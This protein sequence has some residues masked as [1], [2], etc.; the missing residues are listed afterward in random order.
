MCIR[1][2]G[3]AF[4]MTVSLAGWASAGLAADVSFSEEAETA[5]TTFR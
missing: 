4:V 1:G 2:R 3:T 5:G